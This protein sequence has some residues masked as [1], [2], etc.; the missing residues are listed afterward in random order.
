M[1]MCFVSSGVSRP[2]SSGAGAAPALGGLGDA[3]RLL[4]L[5]ISGFLWKQIP[6]RNRSFLL[7]L[8]LVSSVGKS[9]SWDEGQGR[10]Q[11]ALLWE[12]DQVLAA[13]VPLHFQ[14]KIHRNRDSKTFSSD[15]GDDF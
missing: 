2:R 1:E 12:Q 9:E 13:H 10:Q 6:S 3:E 4:S 11:Q 5:F 15:L 7:F 8:V 14:I